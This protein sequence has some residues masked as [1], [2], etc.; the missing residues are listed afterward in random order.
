MGE[1]FELFLHLD[2][3]LA[4]LFLTYNT[5]LYWILFL[6]IFCE[7]GLIVM[8]FLPGD[9]LLF[10]AGALCSSLTA[11][12]AGGSILNIHYLAL[13]LTLA[14]ILGDGVNYFIGKWFGRILLAKGIVKENHLQKTQSFYQQYGAMTVVYARFLPIVRTVA[15]FVAGIGNMNYR[16]FATY[17]VIGALIWVPLF[18]YAGYLFGGLP[19]IKENFSLVI[20]G[21]IFVSV[22]PPLYEVWKS[23]YGRERNLGGL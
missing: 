17:N 1:I 14:A 10:A 13:F 22:L 8:P 20:L 23:R 18:L 6:I 2:K 11:S 4:E 16:K 21:I 19:L 3:H 9:S 12:M 7:T 5:S 15:P